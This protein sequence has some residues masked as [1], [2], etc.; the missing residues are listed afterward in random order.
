MIFRRRTKQ[1]DY[2]EAFITMTKLSLE[3]ARS[4]EEALKNFDP[5]NLEQQL[6]DIHAI[7]HKA[8]EEQHI[9]TKKLMKEFVTPIEREDILL[10]GNEIDELTDTIEDV[11]IR[12]FMYNIQSMRPEALELAAVIVKSCEVLLVAMK[13]F[14]DFGKSKTLFQS[15]IDI[16]TLEEKGDSIYIAAMRRLYVEGGDPVEVHAWSE[17]FDRLEDCC[18]ACEHVANVLESVVMKNI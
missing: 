3:A 4:L 18:D 11:L 12:V 10:L 5:A 16:N 9:M 7:E 17:T 14:P 15:I 13:E 8:D 1:N 2:F 6:V